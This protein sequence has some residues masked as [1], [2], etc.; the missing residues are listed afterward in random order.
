MMDDTHIG[1]LPPVSVL[2]VGGA[3][4]EDPSKLDTFISGFLGIEGPKVLVHGGGRSATHLCGKLGIPTRMVGGRR[5]TDKDTL[6]VVVMTY[7]GSTNKGVVVQLA[8]R[9]VRALGLSG[10]DLGL[11]R[12]HV[13]PPVRVGEDVCDFGYVGDVDFVDADIL[14][15]LLAKDIVPVLCP[16]TFDGSTLLNTNADSVASSVAVALSH[17]GRRPVDLYFCFEMGG[18]L[19]SRD[20][21]QSVI[22]DLRVGEVDFLIADGT[23]DGGM[24]PKVQGAVNAVRSGVGRVLITSYMSPSG[25]TVIMP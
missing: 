10:A 2:K 16:L 25:G 12:S 15:L 18:I 9:G 1:Q 19:R 24:I 13:R 8:R 6:D 7:A 11:V 17:G 3:V 4:L 23:I 20:D 22:P 5:V 21:S 14:D